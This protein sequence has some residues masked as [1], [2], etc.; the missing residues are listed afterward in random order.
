MSVLITGGAGYIGSHMALDLIDAGRACVVLDD[1]TTGF[2]SAVPAAAPLIVGDIG[3]EVLVGRI[4][5]EHG[6][7]AIIHFAAKSVVPDSVADPL[8]YYEAN[9][10]KSA[11]LV[12]A[13][14]RGGVSQF[15]FSSTAAVYGDVG[16]IPVA[17]TAPLL[18]VSPYG[19]TKLATEW[20]IED[21]AQAH[22]FS[23]ALLRYF[24]V[25]GADPQGRAGQSTP[26]ATHLIKAAC[27][28][29]LG[30]RDNLKIFGTDFDTP[31]GTGV[32][33]YIQVTDLASAHSA[34]L[35][36]LEAGGASLRLNCGYGAGY[37]VRQVIAAVEH[38]SGLTVPVELAPRRPGD[39]ASVI[40]D[41]TLIRATLPW[42]PHYADL[43]LI[44]GQALDWERTLSA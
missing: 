14:V 16:A 26:A 22:G 5:A 12:R 40:A 33:D 30:R 37:S 10:V 23:Y 31:D 27:Q 36:H 43:E 7:T 6:V 34:A 29:A 19:R 21:T 39:P 18:A 3:N 28:A 13:A 9:T 15:V 17:E 2:A 11:A 42:A 41:S 44:V 38:A 24:N 4:I 32:R 20:L 1:L 8:T 35:A 25:A